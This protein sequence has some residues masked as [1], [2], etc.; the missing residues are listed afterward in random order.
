M[1]GVIGASDCSSAGSPA[2]TAMVSECGIGS[3]YRKAFV[4]ADLL[5]VAQILKHPQSLVELRTI[6]G[7]HRQFTASPRGIGSRI[8]RIEEPHGPPQ[9][10]CI[11]MRHPDRAAELGFERAGRLRLRQAQELRHL[12]VIRNPAAIEQE[13]D[14]PFHALHLWDASTAYPPQ[15]LDESVDILIDVGQPG[16]EGTVLRKGVGDVAKD[17]TIELRDLLILAGARDV[18]GSEEAAIGVP[19]GR[20]A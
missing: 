7:Q 15:A 9:L 1:S 8:H 6:V 2:C 5:L 12:I 4:A 18:D 13:A 19:G 11:T 10:I 16:P 14:R 20:L 3:A 17:L